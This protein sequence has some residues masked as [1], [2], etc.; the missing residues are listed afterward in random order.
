MPRIIDDELFERVQHLLDRN[1][2]A[3][4]R[5]RGKEEY[6]LTTKLFCGYDREM[7]TGYGGTSKSGT[8]YRYYS[9]N[10]AKKRKC[11]KK[12]VRKEYIEDRVVREC[13]AML[14]DENIEKLAMSVA[15]ACEADYDSSAVKRLRAAIVEADGAIENLWKALEKGQEV[16]MITER[17]K[18]RENER[19]E[20]N[21]QIAIEMSRE[22]TFTEPQVKAFLHSLKKGS[23]TD[24]QN[25]RGII[26]IFLQAIYLKDDSFTLMLNGG[27]KPI[28]IDDILLDD[29]ESANDEYECSL[30]VAEAPPNQDNPNL[31]PIGN[32]FG[33]VLYLKDIEDFQ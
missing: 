20:L 33:F 17:I 32:G 27:S 29:I 23:I 14:T 1:K 19:N 8:V 16:E 28:V 9:C 4:A 12:V 6:L 31:I 11:N 22:I 21:E 30:M 24:E 18:K 15:A 13:Y 26:N 3:P 10:N 25:R 2:K 7:M 5:T